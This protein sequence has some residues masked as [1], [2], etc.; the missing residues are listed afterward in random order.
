MKKIYVQ[1]FATLKELL[2]SH[3]PFLDSLYIIKDAK[4]TKNSVSVFSQYIIDSLSAGSPLSTL[5]AENSF[6]KISDMYISVLKNEEKTGSIIKSIGFLVERETGKREQRK[7]LLKTALYSC[8]LLLVSLLGSVLLYA[9]STSFLFTLTKEKL[10][11][12]LLKACVFLVFAVFVFALF[13]YH[14][15][16]EKNII[17]F[18]H[19]FSFLLN[20]GFDTYTA[21]LQSIHQFKVGS[22][23]RQELLQSAKRMHN[24]NSFYD[25]IQ[26]T[27]FFTDAFKI[28]IRYAMESGNLVKVVQTGLENEMRK[29]KEVQDLFLRFSEPY[30]ILSIGGYLLILL[31]NIVLPL[32]TQYGDLL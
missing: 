23:L 13:S 16:K 2:E 21:F 20:S 25:A 1:F 6:V 11:T 5:L 22:R 30:M 3:I 28:K 17:L 24:G 32:L 19:S 4:E 29:E 9:F 15:F 7:M 12:S 10:L 27:S 31:Q 26:N 8:M 18:F 14:I